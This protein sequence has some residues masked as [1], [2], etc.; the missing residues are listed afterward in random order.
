MKLFNWIVF[1]FKFEVNLERIRV[2]LAG[3]VC[4]RSLNDVGERVGLVGLGRKGFWV[5][6][7]GVRV[8]VG[9]EVVLV[10]SC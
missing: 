8:G 1:F 2:L 4:F 7:R 10:E 3:S 6:W 5:V 9:G